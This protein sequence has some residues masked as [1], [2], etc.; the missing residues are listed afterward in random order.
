[1]RKLHAAPPP[2]AAGNLRGWLVVAGAFLGT[3]AAFGSHYSFAAFFRPF[4]IEFGAGRAEIALAFSVCGAVYLLGG[5]ASGI[6]ADRFGPRPL[7]AAGTLFL[8]G[9]LFLAGQADSLMQVY[10]AYGIP[11]ALGVAGIYVPA[12]SNVQ[13]WFE[14]NRGLAS[15]FAVTGIAAG[16]LVMPLLAAELIAALGWRGAYPVLAAITLVLGA[17]ATLMIARQP[18]PAP[19]PQ[20][21]TRPGAK[22]RGQLGRAIR[23]GIFV[24]LYFANMAISVGLYIPFVHLEPFG[25]DVGLPPELAVLLVGLI[26]V[27]SVTGRFLIGGL[28][29]RF[30]R[31]GALACMF[32]GVGLCLLAWSVS[33]DF[34]SLAAFAMFFGAF[35]GGYAALIPAVCA[36]YFGGARLAGIIGCL[37]TSVTVGTLAGPVLAGL[38]YDLSASY[39]WPILGAA[40]AAF[41]AALLVATMVRADAWRAGAGR[42]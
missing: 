20:T 27:G 34:L 22:P 2:A 19:A 38:A 4:E 7:L 9:G 39:T 33:A 10:L 25:R 11:I 14:R 29:D 30:G 1:M 41:V 24:R 15:G 23:S 12:V 36:D 40:L 13:G 17:G 28:A 37:Y 8:S 32:G 16:T 26:G 31:R 35:Y 3:F 21:A 5:A 18:D 6:L 42:L